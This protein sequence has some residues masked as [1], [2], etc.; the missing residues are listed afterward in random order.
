MKDRDKTDRQSNRSGPASGG[1]FSNAMSRLEKAVQDLV[2]VT[3]GELGDRATS[4]INE[5]SKR[6]EAEFRL[7]RATGDDPDK[8]ESHVRR[9]RRH[10][11]RHRF[12]DEVEG[13]Y[14]TLYIDKAEEKVAGVCA[15]FARYF[16]VENWVVRMAALTGLIFIPTIVFPG[17][18]VAYFV[19]EKRH[20]GTSSKRKL[21]MRRRHGH[22]GRP[23]A[24]APKAENRSPKKPDLLKPDLGKPS[25][26][27][28]HVTT[29]LTQ[30]ELKLRR[31][32]SFVT[33]NQY[34]LHKELT[35]IERDGSAV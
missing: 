28:R 3:T 23:E 14:S 2:T 20:S 31:M 12:S 18:W 4:V 15:A 26:D 34:E 25:Q 16:G 22:D 24:Q 19:I 21:R 17:Y 32:E 11:N 9:R 30:V 6:L 8:D 35:K 10:R 27:L 33:S 13:Q 1:E 5:T 7:K 29:D